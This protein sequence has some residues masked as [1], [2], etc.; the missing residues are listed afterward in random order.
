MIPR[1]SIYSQ[2]SLV[3]FNYGQARAIC[4]WCR[5]STHRLFISMNIHDDEMHVCLSGLHN[6]ILHVYVSL[7]C[8]FKEQGS[9]D[10]S[11]G[12]HYH[13][14]SNLHTLYIWSL[15][16]LILFDTAS[17]M[18]IKV[19]IFSTSRHRGWVDYF[20]QTKTFLGE[21]S[22]FPFPFLGC[23]SLKFSSLLW[24]II[25]APIQVDALPPS[26]MLNSHVSIS[27]AGVGERN[28]HIATTRFARNPCHSHWWWQYVH[29]SLPPLQQR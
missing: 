19:V 13:L 4:R 28:G 5:I 7:F 20:L 2:P 26:E 27:V 22:G 18:A 17:Q 23:I 11:I 8:M 3:H 6:I 1:V 14:P 24:I 25:P 10:Q 12:Q 15:Y 21:K 16:L 29:S 9:T